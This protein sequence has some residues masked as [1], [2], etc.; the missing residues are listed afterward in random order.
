MVQCTL[1]VFLLAC[2]NC[3]KSHAIKIPLFIRLFL[4]FISLSLGPTRCTRS[5]GKS[6]NCIIATDLFFIPAILN[7]FVS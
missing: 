3:M 5:L 6:S 2:I 1:H 7:M 4:L